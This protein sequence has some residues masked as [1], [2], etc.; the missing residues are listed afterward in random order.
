MKFTYKWKQVYENNIGYVTYILSPK[1]YW[2]ID[3][4]EVIMRTLAMEI[5]TEIDKQILESFN[6]N[7][8]LKR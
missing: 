1:G 7:G 4:S 6:C 3:I 5:Q 2:Q 8:I